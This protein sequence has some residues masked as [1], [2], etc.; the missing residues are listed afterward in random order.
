M[1]V[2]EC[3]KVI[4]VLGMHRSGTS[5]LTRGLQTLGVELGNNLMPAFEG[6]NSKG[7]WEDL[8]ITAINEALLAQC[9][10]SWHSLGDFSQID[11][12][13]LVAGTQGLRAIGYLA[14]QIERHSIFGLKDPRMARLLP[15]WKLIFQHLGVTPIFLIASRN[16][17][18]VAQS[19]EKRDGLRAERSH[20]LW[21]EHCLPSLLETRSDKRLVINYDR[22]L[23]N[24]REQLLR[25]ARLSGLE[26]PSAANL[27][28]YADR[29]LD[30]QLRHSQFMI[31]DLPLDQRM[32]GETHRLFELLEQLATDELTLDD[33]ITTAQ[34]DG[35]A[36]QLNSHAPLRTLLSEQDRALAQWQSTTE[37]LQQVIT[38]Q[39]HALAQQASAH[40]ERLGQQTSTYDERLRQQTSAY[41]ERLR[42]QASA[43]DERLRQQTSAYDERLLQQ[44]AQHEAQDQEFAQLKEDLERHQAFLQHHLISTRDTIA[45]LQN[46]TSWRITRPLRAAGGLKKRFI[47]QVRRQ[48]KSTARTLY[49]ALPQRFRAP[50][51]NRTFTHLGFLFRGS[52]YYDNWQRQQQLSH[53]KDTCSLYGMTHRTHGPTESSRSGQYALHKGDGSPYCYLPPRRTER[54]DRTLTSFARKPLIS[55]ITPVYGIAPRY[56]MKLVHSVEQQWYS[57][58]EL[59]LVEDAGPNEETRDCMRQLQEPRIQ[60]HFLEQNGGISQASN[61]ALGLARGEYVVFLDHDDELTQDALYEVVKAINEQDPDFIYSDEDKIDSSG[62]FS[63]PFFKPGWSPDALMSIMYTCHLAC[64]RSS[65]VEAVGGLRLG[66]EGAQDYDL[67]LRITENTQRVVHIPKI[68][69]HW[70][71]LPSSIASS[72]EAKPYASEAVRRLK[73]DALHR[74]GLSGHVEPVPQ[75]PGQFR[76]NYLPAGA[77]LVSIIVPTRDNCRILRQCIESILTK[78]TYGAYEIILMDNQSVDANALAYYSSL[79]AHPNI[80]MH[81]YPHAFNFSAINNLA[82]HHA[83][84]EF[85]VFLNDDTQITQ[86]DW[87]Q[88]LLGF[89][90]LPHAGAVGAKLLFPNTTHIQHCGVVNLADGPGHAFYNA[91]S[92]IPQYFGRNILDWNWLAVTGACLMVA[93]HKFEAVGGFDEAL[94]IAYNDVDLCL[95]LHKAGWHNLVCSAV[96]LIHHESVSRG[97]DHEDPTKLQRLIRE[98]SKLFRK[99]PHYFMLDPYYNK[100]LHQNSV[101]FLVLNY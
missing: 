19:L 29:F 8:E 44:E 31:E 10:H 51:L 75:M 12:P 37:Q 15:F 69:Y 22:L 101:D 86:G 92:E 80:R 79:E 74:R 99:H 83:A 55:I 41:D 76:I 1:S 49:H 73:E 2:V 66:Y 72:I 9:G 36:Q 18:S 95:S 25:I 50:L 11:W 96:T 33:P 68:L 6:N 14:Q 35:L 23:S 57:N 98:R 20:L 91:Q 100:N 67:I 26:E 56:L 47:G 71:I 94:P 45:E 34:L 97:V 13:S 24:P 42:Q 87:L 17:I 27:T 63:D 53:T 46:S 39:E 4:V 85:L 32:L 65:L 82:S 54:V 43:Y 70:R 21:L 28:E 78:T 7:F 88:R 48:L 5:A 59:I 89:A 30:E 90:Q 77:P 60:V 40:D 52:A 93:R 16:P 84:G 61:I 58:W 81:H 38:A 64:I 3:T 62:N